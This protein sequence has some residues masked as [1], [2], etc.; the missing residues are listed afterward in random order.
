MLRKGL[1]LRI[2][3][4]MRILLILLTV[5]SFPAAAQTVP[6][7][8]AQ[9]QL[10]FAPLVREAAPAVVRSLLGILFS[11]R[12]GEDFGNAFGAHPQIMT[13]LIFFGSFSPTASCLFMIRLP[14]RKQ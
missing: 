14:S 12:T 6:S 7:S 13:I 9:I 1:W 5:L 8:A 4:G 10:S 11:S 3:G 2:S